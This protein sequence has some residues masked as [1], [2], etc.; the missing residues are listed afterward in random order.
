MSLLF[1]KQYKLS[2]KAISKYGTAAF[3][4]LKDVSIHIRCLFELVYWANA[5][6]RYSV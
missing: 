6:E 2:L 3:C 5:T 4:I 1:P